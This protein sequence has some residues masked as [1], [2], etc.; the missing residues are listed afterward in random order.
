MAYA[1][2]HSMQTL[3]WA[4]LLLFVIMYSFA[5]TFTQVA[6]DH[7]NTTANGTTD[8]VSYL[9]A[10]EEHWATLPRSLY[11]LYAALSNGYS[12]AKLVEPLATISWMWT[13]VFIVY[14]SLAVFGAV[15][16]VTAVFVES[17]MESTQYFMDLKLE[18]ALSTKQMHLRHLRDLFE[19]I[20]EDGSG[21]ITYAELDRVLAHPQF[22]LY[23]E[24]MDKKCEDAIELFKMLDYDGS[25]QISVDEFCSGIFKLK[26]EASSF[27]LHRLVHQNEEL[28]MMFA[29]WSHRTSS[30]LREVS[31]RMNSLMGQEGQPKGRSYISTAAS[32][33]VN[34]NVR[35]ALPSIQSSP[36]N[37]ANI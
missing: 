24:H 35:K 34:M 2:Q 28:K 21:D 11:S 10:L 32:R 18:E 15:N 1:L 20:D 33:V 30:K 14:I 23:L 19:V 4:L 27:D 3:F 5:L 31:L 37:G 16:V 26:G 6:K 12:W 29:T 13:T 17:A 22:L 25:G 36:T 9:D 7:L 8:D